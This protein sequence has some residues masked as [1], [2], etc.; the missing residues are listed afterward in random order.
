MLRLDIMDPLQLASNWQLA[1]LTLLREILKV[2]SRFG[3]GLGWRCRF[4]GLEDPAT[5]TLLA[6]H[7][8][9]LVHQLCSSLKNMVK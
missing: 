3:K 6:L 7:Q 1:P 2:N 9:M 4:K 5:C 8:P